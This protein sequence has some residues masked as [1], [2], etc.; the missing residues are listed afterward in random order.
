[1]KIHCDY[2]LRQNIT[3]D[4]LKTDTF[5]NKYLESIQQFVNIITTKT[6]VLR[7]DTKPIVAGKSNVITINSHIE[8]IYD[9]DVIVALVLQESSYIEYADKKIIDNSIIGF[10]S[11][12]ANIIKSCGIDASILQKDDVLNLLRQS[13]KSILLF[14]EYQ[15][16][17]QVIIEKYIGYRGYYEALY[18]RYFLSDNTTAIIKTYDFKLNIESYVF[19]ITNIHHPLYD[20]ITLPNLNEFKE[21]IDINNINRL[22]NTYDSLKLAKSVLAAIIPLI[23]IHATPT[24]A[25]RL[26]NDMSGNKISIE[27]NNFVNRK[28]QMVS[29]YSDGGNTEKQNDIDVDV[30]EIGDYNHRIYIHRNTKDLHEKV[31]AEYVNVINRAINDA[32]KLTLH[33]KFTFSNIDY[34]ESDAGM[35]NTNALHKLILSDTNIFKQSKYNEPEELNIHISLDMS[36]SIKDIHYRQLYVVGLIGY[37]AVK[38]KHINLTVSLR[39]ANNNKCKLYVNDINETTDFSFLY[40]VHPDGFTPEALCY[41]TIFSKTNL[42][43]GRC[44]FIT[45]TDGFPLYLN[46]KGDL[47]TEHTKKVWNSRKDIVKIAYFIG[48]PNTKELSAFRQMYSMNGYIIPKTS[49]FRMIMKH[50]MQSI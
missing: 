16:L 7:Y 34:N 48:E 30:V 13:F 39:Y 29:T 14:I 42:T 36:A 27:Q 45:F 6:V 15:R 18:Y 50:L 26:S 49:Q 19:A 22:R 2:W 9:L 25:S 4:L 28:V 11:I 44:L 17:D 32:K 10:K 5:K 21:L 43:K 8:S 20:T 38:Y 40:R 35:L 12:F 3:D 41:P 33:N 1:M 23:E 31:N 37:F 24:E 46:Y 47:A